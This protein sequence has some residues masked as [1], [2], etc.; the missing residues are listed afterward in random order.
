MPMYPCSKCLENRW[1]FRKADAVT[2][3]ATCQSCGNEVQFTPAKL[4]RKA[5]RSQSEFKPHFSREQ[6][7][8]QTGPPPWD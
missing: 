8:S 1:R 5:N 2:I 7:E 6:I 4:K 3:E